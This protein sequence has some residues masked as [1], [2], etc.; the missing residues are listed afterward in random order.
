MTCGQERRSFTMIKST[1][2]EMSLVFL[3]G[4]YAVKYKQLTSYAVKYKHV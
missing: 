4:S 3:M 2:V 1:D